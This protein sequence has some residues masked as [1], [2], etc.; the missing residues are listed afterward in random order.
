MSI[1]VQWPG[2][3]IFQVCKHTEFQIYNFKLVCIQSDKMGSKIDDGK[4][5]EVN[6]M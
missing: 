4:E 3:A 6:R 1:M 5:D 2:S